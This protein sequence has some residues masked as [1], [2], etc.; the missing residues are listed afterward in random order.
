MQSDSAKLASA[1]L[2]GR[3]LVGAAGRAPRTG[4]VNGLPAVPPAL[5]VEV[6]R[7]GLES[8]LDAACRRRLT[9][10]TAGPGWGKTTVVARWIRQH[11]D[12]AP[13]AVTW[14]T[15][16]ASDDSPAA[17]W[18]AVLRSIAQV[19][20]VPERHPL[21]SVTAAA[22]VNDEVLLAMFRALDSLP[23]PL[24]IVLDDFHHIENPNV[25]AALNEL[26]AHDTGVRLMLLTRS[27]PALGLHRLRLR[28]DLAEIGVADLAFD[29]DGVRRLARGAESLDLTLEQVQYVL[30]R[31]EGWPAGVRLATMHLSRTR[32]DGD[33]ESFAGTDP[34]VAEYLVAE[35][36]GRHDASTREFLYR[37]S[38]AE[39]LDGG[40]ADAIVAGGNGLARL[41]MLASANHFVV[42]VDPER[43]VYRYHPLLRDLLLHTLQRDDP[44]GYRDA[45]RAAAR[46]LVSHNDPVRAL[47]HA[48]AARDWP[49]VAEVFF[50]ASP[51]IV[52]VQ[53]YAVSRELMAIPFQSLPSSADLELC[54]AGLDLVS[55]NLD[56]MAVHV[57]AA[58]R[59]SAHPGELPPIAH[60]LLENLAAAAARLTGDAPGVIAA[61][62]AALAFLAN[63]HP[64]RAADGHR[65]IAMTQR[66]VGLLWSG[67]IA[68]AREAFAAMD[69]D[70][71]G[72]D[73]A[74]TIIGVRSHLAWC[75]VLLGR[76][77][78]GEA[79][80]RAVIADASD[81]GWTSLL[82][83]RP[84]YIALATSRMLQGDTSEA[85]QAVASGLAA[86]VGGV[87]LWPTI[88]L[89][90]TKASVAVSRNRPRAAA[91][92]LS[93][94]VSRERDWSSS[95]LLADMAVRAW[96][97]QNLL[98]SGAILAVGTGRSGLELDYRSATF[99]SSRARSDFARGDLAAAERSAANVPDQ[100]ESDDLADLLASIEAWLVRA[101]V[102]DGNRH[103]REAI[104]AIGRA[105]ELARAQSLV[106]PFLVTGSERTVDLLRRI[107]MG[108]ERPDEFVA[109]VLALSSPRQFNGPEPEPLIE[110]LTE[111]ELAVLGEL[112]TMKSNAEIASEFYVSINTVKAHL[113][114]LYRKLD[115]RSRRE[116]VRRGREL[117][118]LR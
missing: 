42:S 114:N 82:Q 22:G 109:R 115:V 35:V 4:V 46:W 33:L 47:R 41:E 45:H 27:E 40:L 73:F 24:L 6:D 43:T 75:D 58:R 18:G 16:E 78:D 1:G 12:G 31:T 98:V 39:R 10:V 102:A 68:T 49:L 8:L 44:D 56:A 81:K 117:G 54:A 71:R 61:S 2:F 60:A 5:A 70:D 48:T 111:R 80:A 32:S 83:L 94:T 86:D 95:P 14:L 67:D 17:F 38:V 118:L 74:L 65:A 26:V 104:E 112:S 96:T 103:P 59:N 29:V 107:G 85:V 63:A 87:E 100:P 90:L 84:A 20:V 88:A 37:T 51:C 55:G 79:T 99:W 9:I 62:D 36:L 7:P 93:H 101:L 116:A 53:R 89:R 64:G 77:S 91:A 50:Q 69:R 19:G 113:K 52:G 72:A 92:A 105:L 30:A 76:L 110:P 21:H 11:P 13:R 3:S 97:D 15:L 25:L 106:R 28:G 108:S 34:S 23:E 57:N 66:A